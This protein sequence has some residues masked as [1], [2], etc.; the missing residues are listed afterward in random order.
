MPVVY[1]TRKEPEVT[2]RH[3]GKEDVKKLRLDHK[4]TQ[5]QFGELIG[6]TR[7]VVS[8]W[9]SGATPVPQD[10]CKRVSD[11][12]SNGKPDKVWLKTYA[13]TTAARQI[14]QQIHTQAAKKRAEAYKAQAE[15]M[16]DARMDEIKEKIEKEEVM[17]TETTKPENNTKPT[18]S[19]V[20]TAMFAFA[21]VAMEH[22]EDK[23]IEMVMYL[24][25]QSLFELVENGCVYDKAVYPLVDKPVEIQGAN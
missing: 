25:E 13:A 18:F 3:I 11:A 9:E 19:E 1:M 22:K 12:V 10:L 17:K 7:S 20:C 5:K 4:M 2:V 16:A 6:V 14:E 15:A 8:K 23:A 24:A 21:K